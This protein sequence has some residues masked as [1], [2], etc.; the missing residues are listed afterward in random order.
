MLSCQGWQSINLKKRVWIPSKHQALLSAFFAIFCR[1]LINITRTGLCLR[2]YSAF[3]ANF[4]RLS[5][6]TADAF[7]SQLSLWVGAVLSFNFSWL[8]VNINCVWITLAFLC[9]EQPL[10]SLFICNCR[11][12]KTQHLALAKRMGLNPMGALIFFPVGTNLELTSDGFCFSKVWQ[13][14]SHSGRDIR[15]F[16]FWP[17]WNALQ[18]QEWVNGI[19]HSQLNS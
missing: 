7:E 14:L 15:N 16:L 13:K 8:S 9:L 1:L 19:F 2:F 5:I 4:C 3:L 17:K 11:L 10:I 12:C 18:E 6:N